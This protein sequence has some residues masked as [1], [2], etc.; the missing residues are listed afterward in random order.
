MSV[1][2]ILFKLLMF[3][4]LGFYAVSGYSLAL[5]EAEL[6]SYLNQSL[7]VRIEL[8]TDD[9][10]DINDLKVELKQSFENYNTHHQLKYEILKSGGAN[11]LKITSS[12]V[13][14]EP[15]VEFTLDIG[16]SDGHV[17]KDY[18]FLIDPPRN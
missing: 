18:S 17:V 5:S 7:D 2:K 1:Y 9:A 12:D 6:K 10:A 8:K 11:I 3:S 15:I 13:V 16:W 14:R 4:F